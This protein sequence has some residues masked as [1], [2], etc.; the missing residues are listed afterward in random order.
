[1]NISLGHSNLTSED[2]KIPTTLDQLKLDDGEDLDGFLGD[3]I[4]APSVSKSHKKDDADKKKEKK[5]KPKPEP[6]PT[7]DYGSS[8]YGSSDE[9]RIEILADEDYEDL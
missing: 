9:G 8:D 6:A 2:G 5:D 7:S 4:E 1:L 3:D